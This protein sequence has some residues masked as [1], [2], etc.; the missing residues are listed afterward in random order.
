MVVKDDSATC[1]LMLLGSVGKSIVAV[2]AEELWDGSYEEVYFDMNLCFVDTISHDNS[3]DL[4]PLY[5][6]FISD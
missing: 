4:T 2:D 6:Y 5:F 3:L 1:N